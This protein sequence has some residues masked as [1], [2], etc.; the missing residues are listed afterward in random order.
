M[1]LLLQGAAWFLPVAEAARLNNAAPSLKKAT[2]SLFDWQVA[3]GA[4]ASVHVQDIGKASQ[5]SPAA[6]SSLSMIGD[7]IGDL[8][9]PARAPPP[10]GL[11][12]TKH[13]AAGMVATFVHSST[14]R[15]AATTVLP[16]AGTLQT[17]FN[18]AG[19][20][21]VLELVDG[22]YTGNGSEVIKIDKDITVRA[23]NSGQAILDGDSARRVIYITNGTVTLEGLKLT[24]G[25]SP[26][27]LLALLHLDLAYP[28]HCPVGVLAF[29]G[30]ATLAPLSAERRWPPHRRWHNH[31]QQLR[32]PRQ[33]GWSTRS[34]S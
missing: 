11:L 4:G 34:P 19:A 22:T 24:K 8:L 18:A 16:G 26:V 14:R 33:P 12:P 15:L 25:S 13:E 32:H 20:G 5:Q 30:C 23:Q 3:S 2:N 27:C 7:S 21:D 29:H 10:S 6:A 1:L 31:A 9:P 28:L 17:A